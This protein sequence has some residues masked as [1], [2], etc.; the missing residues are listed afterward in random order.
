M[1]AARRVRL[2]ARSSAALARGAWAGVALLLA[3]LFVAGAPVAFA[4]LHRPCPAAPCLNW[5]LPPAAMR[6]LPATGIS[7]DVYAGYLVGIDLASAVVWFAVGALVTWRAPAD[8]M[9]RFAAL[10]L[11]LFRA[12]TFGGILSTLRMAEPAWA[13]AVTAVEL[14]GQASLVPFLLLFPDGRFVPRWTLAVALLWAVCI[15]PQVLLPGSSLDWSARPGPLAV[16]IMA[17]FCGG[18]IAA[19]VY[20]YRRVSS[21]VQRQQTKWAVLGFSGALAGVV[22]IVAFSALMR[23]GS[24]PLANMIGDTGWYVSLLLVPLSIGVSILRYRLWD[25]DLIIN[26]ALVYGALTALVAS[27]YVL[28]VGSL[29]SLLRTGNNLAVSLVATGLVA[30]LFQPLRERLQRG[31]DRLMYGDRHDPYG[32][33]SRLSRR[34]EGVEA[35]DAA[36]AVFVDTVAESLKLPYVALAVD[37]GEASPVVASRGCP[38]PLPLTLPLVYGA[39]AV[40]SLS[41]V[42][43]PGETSFSPADRRLLGDL[44]RQAGAAA[45]AA[46]LAADL[47]RSRER[48]VTA[49]EEERRRLRRDLHDGLGPA[50]G[51]LALKIGAARNL[52]ARDQAAADALLAELAGDVEATVGDVRRLVYNLRPPSLDELGLVGAIRVRAAQYGARPGG[53]GLQVLVE[54]PERLPPLPAAVEVAAYRIALEALTNVIRHARAQTCHIRIAVEGGLRVDVRDDGIGLPAE[55]RHGVGLASMRERAEE[56]GGAVSVEALPG[57]GTRVLALLPLAEGR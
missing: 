1:V 5:Q 51:A 2:D 34:L 35:P 57:G 56:L 19:Q 8:P 55:R 9:A 13:G 47:R 40:G 25:V 52:L 44:A 30:L 37:R 7:L 26:R 10:F 32:V 48:L 17:G 20:R 16:L 29:G 18:V 15:I 39:E 54:A 14:L 36:L 21:R 3:S 43:R 12:G 24:S 11:V 41:L 31:A 23:P 42:P 46:R 22:A 45:Y 38:V 4:Q 50:L 49:R 53:G 6:Q 33:L 28:A 27:A